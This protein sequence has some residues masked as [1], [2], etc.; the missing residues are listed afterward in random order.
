MTGPIVRVH[1]SY[2]HVSSLAHTRVILVANGYFVASSTTS[3]PSRLGRHSGMR[4]WLPAIQMYCWHS[5][6]GVWHLMG[7]RKTWRGRT[8]TFAHA[9]H[10]SQRCPFTTLQS[11]VARGMFRD[12]LEEEFPP[13]VMTELQLPMPLAPSS[14]N[15]IT[16]VKGV[17]SPCLLCHNWAR[18]RDKGRMVGR[19]ATQHWAFVRREWGNMSMAERT[20]WIDSHAMGAR[21]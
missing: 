2:L 1:A 4:P 8:S 3:S 18:Q 11:A 13:E 20:G 7:Q 9:R 5:S 6:S 17:E 21:Q 12:I 16:N 14:D 10:H 15:A 19:I